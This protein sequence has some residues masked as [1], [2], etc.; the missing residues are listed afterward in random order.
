[1]VPFS[2]TVQMGKQGWASVECLNTKQQGEEDASPSLVQG[3][4]GPCRTGL[5]TVF[6]VTVVD[7]PTLT[8]LVNTKEQE[9]TTS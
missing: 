2:V 7:F 3:L 9:E 1:M 8:L 6:C 4:F 5:C